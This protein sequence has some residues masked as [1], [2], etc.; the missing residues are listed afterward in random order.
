[1]LKEI[2]FIKGINHCPI[3]RKEHR[4]KLTDAFRNSVKNALSKC[5]YLSMPWKPKASWIT[6][7]EIKD[8]LREEENELLDVLS[9]LVALDGNKTDFKRY[10]SVIYEEKGNVGK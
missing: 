3:L 4:K 8:A 2:E 10:R 6:A 7:V 1:M 5:G 9:K